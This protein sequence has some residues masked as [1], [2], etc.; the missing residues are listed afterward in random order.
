MT[1]DVHVNILMYHSVA[2][3]RGPL[4]VSPE[5]FRRQLDALA[6]RGFRC[7]AL[8]D[9]V[10]LLDAGQR[11]DRVAVLTF[12][13]GYGDFASTVVPEVEERGW[14]CTV[15]L[16]TGLVGSPSGWDPDGNGKRRLIDWKQASDCSR[17]GVEIGAHGMTHADLT[18]L[19]FEEACRDVDA[20]KRTIE[21]RVGSA[22]VSFAAPY[23]RTTSKLRA[24]ISRSFQSA[25][26]TAMAAATSASDRYDLPRIDMW[27]FRS[28]GRW[29]AY[30]DG[31]RT[32]FAVRQALRTVRLTVRAR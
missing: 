8:R 22:V 26:G 12:D 20:S 29:S 6:V 30:L 9:Y 23:G 1:A 2:N 7:V 4:A 24:H 13:D 10:G 28:T 21:D 11:I 17:R 27:Y 19:D 16:P 18:K 3:G 31:A 32:Y 15:F 25:V 5:T 14:S